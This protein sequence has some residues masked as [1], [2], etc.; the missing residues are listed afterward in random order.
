M[1]ELLG[2]SVGDWS[3]N[4]YSN[5]SNPIERQLTTGIAGFLPLQ[6]ERRGND[7]GIYT[8]VGSRELKSRKDTAKLLLNDGF[9]KVDISRLWRKYQDYVSS[10]FDKSKFIAYAERER[11]IEEGRKRE[12]DV[13]Y[14][15][16]KEEKEKEIIN[17]LNLFPPKKEDT[18]SLTNTST[19]TIDK[20]EPNYLLY[21]GIG[22]AI[23]IGAILI[24]KKK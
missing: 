3:A 5:F 7:W 8:N 16:V 18:G 2:K 21:G 17:D 14:E 10:K 22:L 11:L 6:G 15:E 13:I 4:E 9:T 19:S 24:F 20:K 23:L 1:V 12:D